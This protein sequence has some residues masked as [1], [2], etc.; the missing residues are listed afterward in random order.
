MADPDLAVDTTR[1]SIARVYDYA[2]GGKD[3]F[4]VDR[5]AYQAMLAVDPAL[6]QMARE[7]RDWSQRV[8][9]WLARDVGIEQ[10]LDCGSGLPTMENTHQSAQRHNPDA[11][12]VYVDND[13]V[14]IMHGR[15]LL[16]DDSNSRFVGA[17][18]NHPDELLDRPEIAS[19]LEL[20]EPVALILCAAIHHIDKLDEER[21]VLGRYVDR[22]ASGS[23]V[24]LTH[25]HNP[26]DGGEASRFAERMEAAYRSTSATTHWRSREEI[27]SLF[28]GLELVEPGLV[29][30]HQ[31]WPQG[32]S[33]RPRSALFE[34]A[35]G[36]VA[37]KP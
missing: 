13:P 35:L 28:E 32:P 10:F 14:V 17:D 9:R 29:P 5:L 27:E 18:L 6:P 7:H 34:L 4:E 33:L 30:L 3:N 25:A 26:G 12:V 15:V 36:A 21:R 1:P 8:I 37:R 19:F 16:A 22:L 2:L 20:D 11:L 31:W 24:V 23:Y